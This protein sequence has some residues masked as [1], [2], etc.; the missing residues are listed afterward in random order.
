MSQLEQA[1]FS[2][3]YHDT[4]DRRLARF[5]VTL[6][7]R[8]EKR[9][10]ALAAR[11][12]PGDGAPRTRGTGGPPF[13]P[14]GHRP[15]IVG[16]LRGR[17]RSPIATLRTRRSG[18]RV[19]ENGASVADVTVDRVGDH[20]RTADRGAGRRSS[21]WSSLDGD[22]G[23]PST[24]WPRVHSRVRRPPVRRQAEG[25]PDVRVPRGRDPR[26]GGGAEQLAGDDRE[27][28]TRRSSAIDPG[29]RLG[30]DLEDL[31][32][33]RVAHA[34]PPGADPARP[35]GRCST[36]SGPTRCSGR[37]QLARRTSR[38][39]RARPRRSSIEHLDA[40]R[41]AARRGRA[42]GRVGAGRPGRR[43]QPARAAR[44]GRTLESERLPA[45]S[46]T[47]STAA[48]RN[49][50]A[51]WPSD[52]TLKG[53]AAG[54]FSRLEKAVKSTGPTRATRSCIELRI[55]G[56]RARYAA[57]LA[58]PRD[59]QAREQVRRRG[60]TVPGRDRRAPGRGGRGGA[61]PGALP[62]VRRGA[63]SRSRRKARGARGRRR[64]RMPGGGGGQPGGAP[65]ARRH[66]AR[67][68]EG[69]GPGRRRRRSHAANRDGNRLEVVLVHRPRVRRLDAPEGQEPAG[70]ARRSLCAVREVE[71]ETGLRCPRAGKELPSARYR[72][73]AGKAKVVRY[74]EMSPTA[75]CSRHHERGRRSSLGAR[76]TT[77][78][79]SSRTRGPRR[80]RTPWTRSGRTERT[81]SSSFATPGPAGRRLDRRRRFAAPRRA[82]PYA[83]AQDWWRCS[84]LASTRVLSSRCPLRPDG[85]AARR[86]ARRPGPGTRGAG[87][88][89]DARRCPRPAPRA[90]G[91]AV[92]LLHAR[93]R[94]GEAHGYEGPKGA[95]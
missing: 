77:L 40:E 8:V 46:S 60:E 73:P 64:R 2:S 72:G 14:G 80:S 21:R 1:S 63:A 34:P 5:G 35:P 29:D 67:A 26:V 33:F 41:A 22:R 42:G 11:R 78:R 48:W 25:L 95:S 79:N 43:T 58:E 30:L 82:G 52:V 24:G 75:G 55:R 47:G 71:E 6:R 70:R 50:P 61:D 53:L 66:G 74:W 84:A 56:K 28:G 68:G 45:T 7:R 9:E 37:A 83:G 51:A 57:E 4:E 31:H 88:G 69:R 92:Q 62:V 15:T 44:L 20:G 81:A 86:G 85:R 89:V 13:D 12:S 36:A 27:A 91:C 10:G 38:G 19:V 32:K 49:P 3:T 94:G 18:V 17:A 39:A 76:S 65:R 54:E 23:R 90:G 16:L 87:R 59:R 93:R